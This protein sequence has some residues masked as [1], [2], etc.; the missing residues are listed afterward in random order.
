M[1]GRMKSW[2]KSNREIETTEKTKIIGNKYNNDVGYD[3][4]LREK[5]EEYA[6]WYSGDSN[7][8]LEYYISAKGN[9]LANKEEFRNSNDYFWATVGNEPEVKCTHSGFPKIIIDTLVSVLGIPEITS[10]TEIKNEEGE[11]ETVDDE[12]TN[13]RI[14]KII[15]DNDF[16]NVLVQEQA[17]YT[18]V[19]GDGAFFINIDRGLSDYPIIEFIDGR[20]IEFERKANRIISITA[21]KYYRHK[22]KGYMLTD[23]RSTKLTTTKNGKKKRVSTIEYHLYELDGIDTDEVKREVEIDIIPQTKGLKDWVDND[24]CFYGIDKMLAVPCV[25]RYNKNTKR[26]E[27]FF[28]G[29][30]DLFDDLDQS[31]SQKS[32]VTKLSTPVDYIPEELID[33]DDDGN[34]MTPNRYDRRYLV[35]KGDRNSVGQNTNQ[36]IT[37]QP[38]LNFEQYTNQELDILSD[39]LMGLMSPSTLGIDVAKKDN[40]D[41]QREKEKITL[42]TRDFLIDSES[43]ILKTLFKLVLQVHDYMLD[44]EGEIGEYD[45]TINYPDYANPSF[46]SKLIAL[47]PAFVSGAMSAKQFVNELWGESL[48]EEEKEEEIAILEQYKGAASQ[49]DDVFTD[50]MLE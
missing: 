4:V 43:T 35:V 25:F 37:T 3:P 49:V 24:Y 38:D 7:A 31:K 1:F 9:Q 30:L 11:L 36:V 40:A 6:I 34:P 15:E 44:P 46:E 47:M 50:Y 48:S 26:G 20:N 17:P 39:A 12:I 21:R 10:S 16:Y 14:I 2:L 42:I 5:Q 8:L 41:A 28:A 27:S 23:K 19:V 29:K 13:D 18:M 22:N 45:I 33:Y 32:N